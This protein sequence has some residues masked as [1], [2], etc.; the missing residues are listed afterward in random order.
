MELLML[1]VGPL[2]GAV[3]GYVT[4]YIAVKML[5]R[6]RHAIKIGRW[7][8]P[9]TPGIFPRRKEQLAKALGNAVGN[10]L[11]TAEDMQNM[12]SSD[13][14]RETIRQAIAKVLHEEPGSASDSGEVPGSDAMPD[15]RNVRDL[16]TEYLEQENYQSLKEQ[17]EEITCR[18]VMAA[19]RKIDLRALV[20]QEG[21]R[22]IKEKTRGTMLAL[23]SSDKLIA[24]L[25][26][27]LGEIAE[28]Y[29]R[30][31]G[32]EIIRPLIKGEISELESQSPREFVVNLGIEEERLLE[33][34]EKVYG[35]FVRNKLGSFVEQFDIAG[36]VE[37][38]VKAMDVLEIEKLVLAVMK[39]ELRAI[40]N[41][42]ALIGFILGLFNLLV[43]LNPWW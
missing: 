7:A 5:F 15:R 33:I 36:I 13:K 22:A 4:N 14:T 21:T 6:P 3:I 24:S 41:L 26:G 28:Q 42:G 38:K 12:L 30:E 17:L 35:Y 31:N 25:M 9:F 29:I 40:V 27:A 37:Q 19:L 43:T 23:I 32:L 20:V 2:L 1:A 11:L 18:K 34:T 8:L 16:L 39:N 10:N